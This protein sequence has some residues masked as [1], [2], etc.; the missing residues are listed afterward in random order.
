MDRESLNMMDYFIGKHLKGM[1]GGTVLDIG[2]LKI[3]EPSQ[4]IETYRDLFRKRFDYIGMD[5]EAGD[6]VDIVG[7][8]NIKGKYDIV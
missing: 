2:S 5:L 3:D 7:Y 6:N 1:D 4:P 8:E